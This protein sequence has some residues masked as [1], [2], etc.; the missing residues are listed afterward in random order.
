MEILRMIQKL[1]DGINN[2]DVDP[3]DVMFGL[4][5]FTILALWMKAFYALWTCSLMSSMVP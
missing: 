2:F 1:I 4:C 3:A 5:G